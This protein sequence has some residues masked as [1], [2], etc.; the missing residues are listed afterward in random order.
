VNENTGFLQGSAFYLYPYFQFGSFDGSTNPPIAFP[1]R[2]SLA[3]LLAL[4]LS[5]PSG[6]TV[7]SPWNPVISTNTVTATGGT[8]GG[9]VGTGGAAGGAGA[10]GAAAGGAGGAVRDRPV[11][12]KSL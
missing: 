7:T 12:G 4:E 9:T 11:E 1:T 5:P 10:G 3:A 2:T 6:Q 8:A